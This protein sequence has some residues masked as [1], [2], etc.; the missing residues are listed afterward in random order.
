MSLHKLGDKY[1]A[2][3]CDKLVIICLMENT[4]NL[5]QTFYSRGVSS[6]GEYGLEGVLE[7]AL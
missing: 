6:A 7:W 3:R 4:Y 2:L 1:K 5:F